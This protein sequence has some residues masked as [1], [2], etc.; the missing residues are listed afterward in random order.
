MRLIRNIAI[1]GTI[2]L[3]VASSLACGISFTTFHTSNEFLSNT[4][5]VLVTGF[6][7][8]DIYDINPSQLIAE[9]LDGQNIEGA[10]IIGIILPVNFNESVEVVT[11]AIIDYNP[12]LVIGMGL[13]P[14][15]HK[16]NVEK[17]GINLKWLPRNE[18]MWFT[19]RRLDP[20]GPFIHL[21]PL[22]TRE[23]VLEIRE[24]G[25]PSCQSFFAGFYVCNAVLY[26]T[27]GFIKEHEISTTAGFIHVPL[28]SSQDPD[29]MDLET[30]IEAVKVAIKTSLY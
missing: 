7:P 16:I 5:I 27:L 9:A 3:T 15:T 25:I 19:P 8:F 23:I 17:C 6:E 30:M 11:Q 2:F 29:G 22:H 10:E 12:L 20:C 21:S 18:S 1:V 28:L 24:A 4:P 13:S 14:R 26:E